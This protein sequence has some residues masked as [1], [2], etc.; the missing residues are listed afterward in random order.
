[1]ST[2]ETAALQPHQTHCL[3]RRALLRAGLLAAGLLLSAAAPLAGAALQAPLKVYGPGGPAPA[4]QEAAA[5][6]QKETGVAVEIVAG[7]TPKWIDSARADA[8]LIYSGSE[9]MMSDF[10]GALQGQLDTADA[11]PLYLRPLAILVR[12]GNPKRI[13]GLKDLLKPGMQV[14]VVQGAGQTGAWEDAAGRL[15]DIRTVKALRKNIVAYPGNSALARDMWTQRPELDAWLIWN[16]WQVSN[17]GL[18]DV[19]PIEKAYRIYRDTGI[20]PTA[21]GKL[22]PE[23]AQ[24]VQFL[25]GPKGAAIFRR[26]GWITP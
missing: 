23:S 21:R 9:N 12:P 8:D 20:A 14:L 19:V 3:Q 11:A 26:W 1:M 4:M 17:P 5:A 15:G 10:A 7:P 16:I 2:R 18:A 22:R 24:F 25:E 6:F 13:A